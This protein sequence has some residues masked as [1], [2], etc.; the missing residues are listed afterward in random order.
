M[1][2]APIC[3]IR[4]DTLY[5]SLWLD[6]PCPEIGSLLRTR[7]ISAAHDRGHGYRVEHHNESLLE[8]PANIANAGLAPVAVYAL[9]ER[10]FDV[11]VQLPSLRRL[12]PPQPCRNPHV[13]EFVHDNSHGVIIHDLHGHALVLACLDMAQA[14]SDA[15]IAFVCATRDAVN[16]LHAELTQRFTPVTLA[17]PNRCASPG[18]RITIA[19]P[20]GLGHRD[21]IGDPI[22][23]VVFL[24]ATQAGGENAQMMMYCSGRARLF[25]FLA[26]RRDVPP[27]IRDLVMAAFGPA[28]VTLP[29]IGYQGR[30]VGVAWA[31]ITNGPVVREQA[32]AYEAYQAGI[33]SHP[34]RNRRIARLAEALVGN[35]PDTIRRICRRACTGQPCR[36][37]IIV[38]DVDHA[39]VLRRRLP[40]WRLITA[41]AVNVVG[42]SRQDR[43]VLDRGR[44]MLAD[45]GRAIATLAGLP[46]VDLLDFDVVLWAA[47]GCDLPAFR[48]T[49]LMC[50]A[51]TPRPLLWV[52]FH[53]GQHRELRIASGLRRLAY[54]A[55][56]WWP[57]GRMPIVA[58]IQHFLARR[59]GGEA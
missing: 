35:N 42:L 18:A 21:V 2:D 59:P 27:R 41:R 58:R 53:D 33:L 39:I 57:A 49:Q 25:G 22:D 37:L 10:G 32:T 24:D 6:P 23:I 29:R 44:S 30:E 15:R 47:G 38:R 19:T 14:L 43:V 50:P 56:G 13:A 11:R 36:T 40:Q 17:F 7:T 4:R 54:D 12:A 8:H 34:V 45:N 51:T 55:R 5:Q 16:R 48:P 26:Q 46:R 31:S 3:T 52:D 9:L 20:H 28:E 1:C